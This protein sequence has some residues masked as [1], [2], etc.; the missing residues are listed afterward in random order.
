MAK[1]GADVQMEIINDRFAI[2]EMGVE[3]FEYTEKTG[4]IDHLVLK[5]SKIP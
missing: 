3:Q 2:A 4:L 5:V 1:Q